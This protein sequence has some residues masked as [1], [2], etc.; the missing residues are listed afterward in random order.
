MVKSSKNLLQINIIS[1]NT[2]YFYFKKFPI[3][4][5]KKKP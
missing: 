1:N 4:Q 2:F 3:K 5:N